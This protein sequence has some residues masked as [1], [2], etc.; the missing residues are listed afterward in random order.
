MGSSLAASWGRYL[1]VLRWNMKKAFG[2]GCLGLLG[3]GV[4]VIVIVAVGLSNAPREDQV[5]VHSGDQASSSDA[6]AS[7]EA[8]LP[9]VSDT[10]RKGNWQITFLAQDKTDE[11]QGPFSSEKAQGEF[12]ILTLTLANIGQKSFALNGHDFQIEA[13]GGIEYA[14]S[15]DGST[16]L[17]GDESGPEVLWLI[18]TIQPGL[19]KDVRVVFDVP[20]NATGLVLDVQSVRFSVPD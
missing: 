15:S 14:L 10:A 11:I 12:R 20:P 13:P 16:R 2:F 7:A 1:L 3:I 19:S 4:I 17:V 6:T 9:S 18:E 8:A 5:V